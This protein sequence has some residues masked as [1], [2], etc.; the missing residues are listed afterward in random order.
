MT[1]ERAALL[2]TV[3]LVSAFVGTAAYLLLNPPQPM[4][5]ANAEHEMLM[6]PTAADAS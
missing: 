1:F 4:F 3:V 5:E 6:Q 2:I